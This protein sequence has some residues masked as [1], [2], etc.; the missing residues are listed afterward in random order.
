VTAVSVAQRAPLDAAGEGLGAADF[1]CLAGHGLGDAQNS[2]LHSI[3]WFRGRAYVGTSRH[4]LP[5]LKLFPPREPPALDPWPVPAPPRVEDLDLHGEIFAVDPGAGSVQL[6]H[7]S[8]D[9]GS[10]TGGLVPRELGYRGMTVF[11]GASDAEPALYVSSISSVARGTAARLLRSADGETFE[12]VGE[13][14]LG[15]PDVATFRS[16]VAFGGHLYAAPTGEGTRWNTVRNPVLLRTDDPVAPDWELVCPPGFGD[17]GNAGI[18][19]VAEFDGCLYVGTFNAVEGFQVWRS[20]EPSSDPG[21]WAKVIE[22]GAYRGPFNEIALSMYPFQGALYIGTGIQNGGYD[23]NNGVGPAAAELIRLWPDGAW[24]L[25]VGQPRRTPDGVKRPLSG[26]GAGFDNPFAGYFW[27]MVEHDRWLYATTYDWTVFLP[28]AQRLP[29]GVRRMMREVGSERMVAEG[30]GFTLLRSRDGTDW[31]V[32]SGNGLGNPYNHGGRTLLS[33]PDG[34]LLGTANPFGPQV[35]ARLMN[36]WTYTDNPSGGA[37]L[38][39]GRS[40][41]VAEHDPRTG[42][43]R[44][45]GVSRGVT[46]VTGATGFLGTALLDELLARGDYVRVF[47]TPDTVDQL[48]EPDSVELVLGDIGDEHA[49]SKAVRRARTIYHLAGVLPGASREKL[50]TVNVHGTERLLQAQREHG[51]ATRVVLAS[52]V[53]VYEGAFNSDAW[54]LTEQ[55]KL[56]PASGPAQLRAYGESKI[57]AERLLLHHAEADGFEPVILRPSTCYG[58][59]NAGFVE[60]IEALLDRD[61]REPGDED[62]FP[63][64]LLHVTDAGTAFRLAGTIPAAA[65][66]TITVAGTEALE[67]PQLR[68]LCR[69]LAGMAEPQRE[70]GLGLAAT[71]GRYRRPYD[72]SRAW[73]ILRFHPRVSLA[74]GLVE[75]VAVACG[76]GGIEE[77]ACAPS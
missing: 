27:R 37:E 31:S 76:D 3:A 1:R 50:A 8:P 15:N 25:I 75:V 77:I 34:L 71:R 2:Y 13:P 28:Y 23:R 72:I 51:H 11:Q 40:R 62:P 26:A 22:R 24:E 21:A 54:P 47:A 7:R 57:A 45:N 66:E 73:R 49:L 70:P 68:A 41:P 42:S 63:V 14:G 16:L 12:P 6:V 32:V 65:G 48:E 61:P 30:G 64:Q 74:E 29:V 67:Y 69:R 17:P 33:T 4:A 18:F 10:R 60:T 35:A 20:A 39:L 46:L 53:A 19:E 58:P 5:L 55:S 38:W 52:S 9:L 56:G 36:G 44:R 43:R 59:G